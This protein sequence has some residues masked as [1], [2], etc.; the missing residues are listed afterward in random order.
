MKEPTHIGER[1]KQARNDK[2]YTLDD[3]Q[4]LTKIQK[5]YLIAIE[6]NRM[7]DLPGEF[8]INTFLRQYAN[9]VG[10]DI[11]EGSPRGAVQTGGLAFTESALPSR[12]ELKRSSRETKFF[13]SSDAKNSLPTFLLVLMILFMLGSIW[14]YIFYIKGDETPLIG[15]TPAPAQTVPADG[16]SAQTTVEETESDEPQSRTVITS[17]SNQTDSP[18]YTIAGLELPNTL[19]LTVDETGNSWVSVTADGNSKLFEGT[20][21]AGTVQTI[22]LEEG[23]KELSVRIGYLPSV[24][25]TF[26]GA[27]VTLPEDKVTNQTQT[28]IFIIE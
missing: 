11:D 22:Q 13:Y 28:L 14:F 10:M 4:Q 2:G 27:A 26:G 21:P 18:S 15:G 16:I 25:V 6:E 7:E 20:I 12:S 3:L 23:L 24:T 5:R 1:L 8:F 17:A 9:A 19:T